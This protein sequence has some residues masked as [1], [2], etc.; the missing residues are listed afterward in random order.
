MCKC[1]LPSGTRPPKQSP[2]P[3]C[4]GVSRL[5][6]GCTQ[7]QSPPLKSVLQEGG[8]QGMLGLPRP[9]CHQSGQASFGAGDPRCKGG[10]TWCNTVPPRAGRRLSL[11][12]L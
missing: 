7:E 12:L 4:C 5:G 1:S 6:R 10:A 9:W 8:P 2:R 11:F 3:P